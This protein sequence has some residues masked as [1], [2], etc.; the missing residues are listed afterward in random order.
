MTMTTE[1]PIAPASDSTSKAL[2]ELRAQH[3]PRG[4]SA[5]T[6]L[7]AVRA[8]GASIWDASGRRYIDF[9]GG[10]GVMNTGHSHPKVV[11]AV[12]RQLES[13]FTHTCFQVVAYESYVQL[14]SRLNDLVPVKAG[15]ANKTMFVSTGAEATENAIKIARAF[16]NRPAI[17]SFDNSFH[18][19]T[20]MGMSLTGKQKP[21]KQ[22]FGPFAPEVYKAPFPMPFADIT[23]KDALRGLENLFNTQVAP[24]NVAA[25]II[26]PVQG[27][28]GFNPAPAAFLRSLR[29]I[30][31]KHGIVFIN[32]EIQCG[33]GR[34]GK[35]WALEHS[36]VTPDLTCIAKSLA[37]GL[38]L[39]AVTGRADIMDAPHPGGLGGT[40]AGNPLACAAALAVLEVFEE[41]RILESAEKLGVRLE[42]ELRV[43]EGLYAGVGEVRGLGA[44]MAIELVK[45][46]ETKQPDADAAT[47]ICAAALE[48]GLI[49]IKCGMHGNAIRILVPLNASV[50]ELELGFAA[51]REAF[52][53]VYA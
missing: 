35:M 14:A 28:G 9:A 10:I 1:K 53:V 49:L 19:R 48:R 47:R 11:A 45:S 44:M 26:E 51:M 36:G 32:D 3:V 50:E 16:T 43:L 4:V 15:H 7:F 38:P 2:L 13:G 22:N 20:L 40:Y 34:T 5:L 12:K 31:D 30:C 21:Y 52:A 33:F 37:G 6:P 24:E 39:A 42:A 41:E 18:G 17:I 46:R 23:T 29:N 25:I 27:E 8:E